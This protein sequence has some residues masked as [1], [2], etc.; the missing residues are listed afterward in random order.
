MNT[1]L[2]LN[3]DNV[4]TIWDVISDE[5]IFKFLSREIQGTLFQM[6]TN[7]LKGFYEVERQ[8]TNNLMDINKK[9]ILL[10]LNHIK[11]TY[12][13]KIYNKIK[14]FDEVPVK[15]SITYEEI[16]NDRKTQFEKDLQLKQQEFEDSMTLKAPPVPEF[17]DKHK[18]NPISEMDKSIQEMIAKRNYEVEQINN[19]YQS[20][21]NQVN[22]WLKPQDT[23][24]KTEKLTPLT[25]KEEPQKIYSKSKYLN[26]DENMDESNNQILKKSVTWGEDIQMGGNIGIN[27]EDEIEA[28]IFK[29][30]KKVESKNPS[31]NINFTIEEKTSEDRIY[32]L[33]NEV[34][35]LNLKID[36]IINIL[37]QNK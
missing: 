27:F 16:Q 9:Y 33:E 32:L 34:K 37:K 4:S 11:Q 8:K 30:L 5:D 18:D 1:N 20:T 3:K 14:I 29:K 36:E 12:P 19:H 21:A 23:S 35:K 24:I 7:N 2:F 28:S 31:E 10:I 22:N 17:A 26:L 6:F 25:K 15:E 13:Q